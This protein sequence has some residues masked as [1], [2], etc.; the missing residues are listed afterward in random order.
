MLHCLQSKGCFASFIMLTSICTVISVGSPQLG[1]LETV[2]S[3]AVKCPYINI[4]N[5]ILYDGNSYAQSDSLIGIGRESHLADTCGLTAEPSFSY[6]VENLNHDLSPALAV[7]CQKAV[8]E[9]VNGCLAFMRQEKKM[10]PW[11]GHLS[12]SM[13]T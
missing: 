3:L 11:E 9:E 2:M 12:C 1:A 6:E 4:I 10:R 5:F 13:C 8:K 7:Y